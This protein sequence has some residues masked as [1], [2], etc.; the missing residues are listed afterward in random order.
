MNLHRV[1]QIGDK[2]LSQEYERYRTVQ[3]K[4][5]KE[6]IP[7]IASSAMMD[8]CEAEYPD[9]T[10]TV[11]MEKVVNYINDDKN[12]KNDE[13]KEAESPDDT[14]PV[15]MKEGVNDRKDDRN[16]KMTWKKRQNP[17]MTLPLL[18]LRKV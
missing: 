6:T 15:E 13:E 3:H 17:Q 12:E 10:S 2:G 9:D 7:R 11:E 14:S 8:I 1:Q 5:R 16:E 4:N 18:I